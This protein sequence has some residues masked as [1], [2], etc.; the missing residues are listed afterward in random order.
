MNTTITVPMTIQNVTL[1]VCTYFLTL[2]RLYITV[3]LTVS[4]TPS[5]AREALGTVVAVMGWFATAEL[6]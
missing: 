1:L 2:F 3:F 6:Y 4:T 5:D